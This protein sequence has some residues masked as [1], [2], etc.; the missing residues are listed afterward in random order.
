M[1]DNPA[2]D[3]AAALA[4]IDAL[5]DT[6][7]DLHARAFVLGAEADAEAI[8]KLL[9][10]LDAGLR[11]VEEDAMRRNSERDVL[12]MGLRRQGVS[13]AIEAVKMWREGRSGSESAETSPVGQAAGGA[14]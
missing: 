1:S 7:R 2:A 9:E 13:M 11:E 10:G 5:S 4:S 3:L 8:L 6:A 12:V 14:A